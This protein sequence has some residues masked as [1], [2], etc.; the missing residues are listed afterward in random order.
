MRRLVLACLLAVG[1]CARP[2][3]GACSAPL[4]PALEID[5]Y[6]GRERAGGAEV[7]DAEWAAF[8]ADVVTPRF[9]DGLSVLNVEGQHRDAAGRIV[10][11]RSKL[12]VVVVFDLQDHRQKVH[13]IS[14]A[15][16][17]RF[18]QQAVFHA[19]HAVCAG[20]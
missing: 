6:F 14:Q 12:L 9:P 16:V 10:R 13:D 1:G 4:R 3:V 7:S 11:E 17:T 18:G 2:D 20:L 15:Y 8:L 5:L 19:E